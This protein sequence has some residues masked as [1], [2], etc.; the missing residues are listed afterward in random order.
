MLYPSPQPVC[1]QGLDDKHLWFIGKGVYSSDCSPRRA[2]L[3]LLAL[4]S[5]LVWIYLH[6]PISA[7]PWKCGKGAD[8]LGRLSGF[9]QKMFAVNTQ[10]AVFMQFRSRFVDFFLVLEQLC[11]WCYKF[12]TSIVVR[13]SVLLSSNKPESVTFGNPAYES[14]FLFWSRPVE[15]DVTAV[16]V[17][18]FLLC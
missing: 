2:P 14:P 18:P 10:N 5:L 15:I 11:Y 6:L 3:C 1:Q 9:T 16:L 7:V 13:G 8:C 4:L 12:L 17:L